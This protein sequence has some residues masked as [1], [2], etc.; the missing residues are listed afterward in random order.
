MEKKIIA[1]WETRGKRYWIELVRV[2]AGVYEY[3]EDGGAGGWFERDT[4]TQAIGYMLNRI[5]GYKD[6]SINFIRKI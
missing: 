1:R 6:D 5:D 3:S 4:D 2:G